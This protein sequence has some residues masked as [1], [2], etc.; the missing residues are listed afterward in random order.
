MPKVFEGGAVAG[1]PVVVQTAVA[2]GA[3]YV[4]TLGMDASRFVIGEWSPR[5]PQSFAPLDLSRRVNGAIGRL[6]RAAAARP[7]FL[8]AG[9]ALP[10]PHVSFARAGGPLK[11]QRKA[12][13]VNGWVA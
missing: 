1:R 2:M 9:Y 7:G 3:G 4:L 13:S 6:L 12:S 11:R 10:L 5:M 8:I